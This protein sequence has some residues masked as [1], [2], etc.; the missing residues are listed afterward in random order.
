M[1]EFNLKKDKIGTVETKYSFLDIQGNIVFDEIDIVPTVRG[2]YFIS[3][4]DGNRVGKIENN[5]GKKRFFI[6]TI[7]F[8]SPGEILVDPVN[9]NVMAAYG[10]TDHRSRTYE[11]TMVSKDTFDIYKKYLYTKNPA[12]FQNIL[13]RLQNGEA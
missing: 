1:E 11:Y 13:R 8:G 5:A 2:T 6:K 7:K 3:K 12:Y 10:D 9:S 4:N